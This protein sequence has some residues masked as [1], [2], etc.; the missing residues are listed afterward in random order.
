M[1]GPSPCL[2]HGEGLSGADRGERRRVNAE[3]AGV[4]VKVMQERAGGAKVETTY[5]YTHVRPGMQGTGRRD[6]SSGSSSS[7]RPARDDAPSGRM[8]SRRRR[9]FPRW[10]A[11]PPNAT[12]G[13]TSTPLN[14]ASPSSEPTTQG[15]NTQE[16]HVLRRQPPL[17]RR[18]PWPGVK[19][20]VHRPTLSEVVSLKTGQERNGPTAD[21]PKVRRVSIR[22]SRVGRCRISAPYRHHANRLM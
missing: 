15:P 6:V 5:A 2:W 14:P 3:R 21:L 10:A 8:Q 9:R 13:A 1:F 11:I 16:N 4:P 22:V 20:I 19:G 12:Q 18:C 7:V 17:T